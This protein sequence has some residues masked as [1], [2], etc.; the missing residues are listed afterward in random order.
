MSE[1]L[2]GQMF[3]DDADGSTSSPEGFRVRTSPLPGRATDSTVIGRRSSLRSPDLLARSDQI[4]SSLRTCL[5]SASEAAIGCS[6]NWTDSGTPGGRA[7]WVLGRSGRRTSGTGCGSSGDGWPTVNAQAE[8]DHPDKTYSTTN[9]ASYSDGRK[10][11]PTLMGVLNRIEQ[12][13][14]PTV[15]DAES[16]AKVTQGAGSAA[17]GNQII[18][19]LAVQAQNWPTPRSEDSEQTGAHAGVT[20]TLTSKARQD[21]PTPNASDVKGASQPEGRRPVC[22]DDLP[23]RVA[24]QDWFT[25]QGRDWKDTGPSQGNR[26]DVNLG[27]QAHRCAGPPAPEKSST[28]G[29][30]R[31]WSTPEAAQGLGG[32][33]SRGGKRKGELLLAGQA[34]GDRTTPGA[35]NPAWV[36]QLQGLPDGW[37]DLPDAVLSRLSATRTPRT[38]RTSS[39]D[40]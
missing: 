33:L 12:W 20:D 2:Q 13:S 3:P 30:R 38:S 39:G 40:G 36:C 28:T 11:Q 29:K 21:W 6:L 16:L 10:C 9:N 35:L 1:L 32:H 17:K 7:W 37:L 25:P 5:R 15:R 8:R 34:K 22:D 31:D 4:G 14:S 18:M 26:K 23:S 19:P 24:R 27:V